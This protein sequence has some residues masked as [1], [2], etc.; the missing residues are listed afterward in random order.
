MRIG[1]LALN[2]LGSLLTTIGIKIY[3]F[4]SSSQMAHFECDV[5]A[6]PGSKKESLVISKEG[7]LVVKT[8]SRPVEGEANKAIVEA[9]ATAFGLSKSK[10]EII[11]G[12]KSKYKR[13]KLL[14][15]ITA[16]KSFE[17]YKQKI[18]AISKDSV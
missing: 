3:H 14:V 13:I 11:R 7:C 9:V 18:S 15:E 5:Y 12:D 6:K 8:S 1:E 10:V 17:F 2:E 4:Q 16:N